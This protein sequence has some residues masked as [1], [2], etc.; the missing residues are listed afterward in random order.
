MEILLGI[1]SGKWL[2]LSL[3]NGFLFKPALWPVSLKLLLIG[4][5]N[6]IY[7][8]KEIKEYEPQIQATKITKAPIFILGHWRTGTSLL[9]KLLSMDPQFTYPTVFDVYNPETFLTTGKMLEQRLERMK[10]EKRPMDNMVVS[11]KDPA[12]DEFAINTLTLRSPLMGWSFPTK[13]AY[14]EKYLT[15]H[16]ISEAERQDWKEKFLYF[17]KKLTF[18]NNRPLLLKSPHHTARIKTLLEIFPDAKFIH[19]R[20]NPY[21]TFRSTYSLYKNTVANLGFGKRD[22]NADM[23]AVIN[24]FKIMYEVFFKEKDQIK[25]GHFFELSFEELEQN[26]SAGIE[27]IYNGLQISGFETYAPI[28]KQYLDEQKDYKKNVHQ[29]IPNEWKQKINDKWKFC[30]D[31]WNYS[32]EP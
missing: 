18:K 29:P 20:R 11:Y 30:F 13:E 7:A 28:L 23:E 21:H 26:F 31:K 19:I 8:N 16:D 10:A 27:K 9:H 2:K 25:E 1:T 24:R 32:I 4:L 17:L 3:K 15:L 14:F 6:S 5:R 22:I 12:E